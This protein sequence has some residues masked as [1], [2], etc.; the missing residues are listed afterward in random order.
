MKRKPIAWLLAAASLLLSLS[1]P[2]VALAEVVT[3]NNNGPGDFGSIQAA[4]E[5]IRLRRPGEPNTPFSIKVLSST[6]AY[7]GPITPIPDVPISG[8]S[9]S[10]TII[11]GGSPT[12]ITVSSNV[13]GVTIRNFTFRSA[14]T[15][16][17]VAGNSSVNIT[18]NV[19]DL[20]GAAT[21]IRV[22][23]SPNTEIVNNT[24]FGNDTA[25][26]TNSDIEI[27]NNIFAHNA[28]AIDDQVTLG[29]L[30]YNGF[31]QNGANGVTLDPT[32]IPN[33]A[34][35]N[36]DPKFVD[37]AGRDFHLQQDSPAKG[38]GNPQYLNPLSSSSDMGAYGGPDSDRSL[39]AVTG[40]QATELTPPPNSLR[41]SWNPSS[42]S[43]V[44]A[45][46]VYFGT[47]PRADSGNS[48]PNSQLVSAT[49]N[50]TVL[51]NL[52]V[53]TPATPAVPLQVRLTSLPGA[54]RVD[55][56]AAQGATGY[57]V[58][59]KP[60]TGFGQAT[61]GS[62]SFL[63]VPGGSTTST[64][65]TGLVD[66]TTYFVAVQARAQTQFFIAVTAV[67]NSGAASSPGSANE[68][69]FSDELA[70]GVGPVAESPISAVVSDFP[71]AVAPFPGLP[72]K[73]CFIATAAYGF[74]S[75]PQVQV[76]R[77]FR[78]RYLMTTGAGRAFVAWY[79][80]CGPHGALFIND[81]PWLKPPLRLALLPLIVLAL[82]FTGTTPLAQLAI[83]TCAVL[84]WIYLRQRLR[85][86]RRNRH[87]LLRRGGAQ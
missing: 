62:A 52:P 24:F 53:A 16:I 51:S 3:V 83:L 74:Y 87:L 25:I 43:S 35:P 10:E 61:L 50:S 4:I 54:L 46:R 27:S 23:N 36:L 14:T 65:I 86:K 33:T 45:Y 41:V 76:L 30:T 38:S 17:S 78:D 71:E 34:R 11:A 22:Q 8:E 29:Q 72:S 58:F 55:W 70:A 63:D 84:S 15:G 57:R 39:P 73:G 2:G 40:V 49:G 37:L 5:S 82:F 21:A 32:S 64:V 56:E 31:F 79:Y 19:F 68:S 9:T 7:T 6:I 80:R 77:E 28:L 69:P 1:A 12:L 85:A 60:L 20:G 44:S 13:T 81:H 48:Y 66:G 47:S 18:N 59:Y 67:I 42:N 26:S 75:A